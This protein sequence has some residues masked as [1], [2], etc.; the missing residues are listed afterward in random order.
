MGW[1]YYIY[2]K[3]KR[4]LYLAVFLDIYSRKVVGWSMKK[5]MKDSLVIYASIQACGKERPSAG[6]VYI[7]ILQQDAIL[8][9]Y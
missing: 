2:T 4:T 6:L 9:L 1:G 7:L 3:Q 5:K 8:D